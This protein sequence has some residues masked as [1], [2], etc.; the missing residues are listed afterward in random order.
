MG[1]VVIGISIGVTQKIEHS[2]PSTL[3][4]SI[5]IAYNIYW[6]LLPSFT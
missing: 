3:I 5:P 2:P 1:I 4:Q 6:L